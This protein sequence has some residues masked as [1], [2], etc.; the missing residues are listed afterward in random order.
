MAKEE[1]L[2]E[3]TGKLKATNQ[4]PGI[5]ALRDHVIVT[6]MDFVGRQLSSGIWLLGDDGKADGIRPRWGKVYKVGPDQTDVTVGQWVYVEHGRWTRGLEVEI[7]GEVFTVRR[8]DPKAMIFVQDEPPELDDTI[9]TAVS[10]GDV[11][12]R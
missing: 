2:F 6:D 1:K 12:T 9:S 11:K 5:R 3:R 10:G 4:V 8:V 7:D